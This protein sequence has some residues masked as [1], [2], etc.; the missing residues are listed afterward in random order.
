MDS[1]PVDPELVAAA[2][3]IG[4]EAAEYVYTRFR[5]PSL[6]ISHKTDGSE[7]T[8][9]DRNAEALIRQRISEQFPNDSVVGEEQEDTA[10]STGRTWVIDPI[11]GT[12]SFVRGVP[13]FA[14]LL[15]VLDEHGPAVGFVS[16][17][18]V[19][20]EVVAGRGRGCS[21][22]GRPA[23][24]SRVAHL[25][26]ACISSS[27][28]DGSWWPPTALNRVTTSG[29]K[30][31][32]WGDGYGYVLLATGRVEAM[33]EPSLNLWDIAP[34]L[35]IVPE[36]GGTITNW[37]GDL[38]PASDQGWIASNGT[39]HGQLLELVSGTLATP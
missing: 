33:I 8:E 29:A 21:H 31:R 27:S 20:E 6:R 36:S 39:L 32:T 3:N 19:N 13:L 17:P 28:F 2:T 23:Q 18:A 22:S 10:G 35:V 24:V 16:C 38:D 15:A 4:R 26:Q 25:D 1:E 34:M 30:T 9:V 12:T 37:N 14:T 11:D 7:V 5:D